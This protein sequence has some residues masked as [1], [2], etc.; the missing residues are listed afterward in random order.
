MQVL[1]FAFLRAFNHTAARTVGRYVFRAGCSLILWTLVSA[2]G[3]QTPTPGKKKTDVPP[4]VSKPAPETKAAPPETV[5]SDNGQKPVPTLTPVSAGA[6]EVTHVVKKGDTLWDLAKEYLKDPFR[7]PDVFQRNTDVVENPHWIYPGETIRIPGSEVKPDVL[8]RIATRPAPVS[9]RTVFAQDRM[10]VMP[11]RLGSSGEVLGRVSV[12]GVP[13]GEIEAAPF[14]DRIG[15]PR[16]SGTLSGAYDRPGI[17]SPAGE[18]RFQLKDRVFVQLPA[19]GSARAG[20]VL[21]SYRLGPQISDVGQLVIPTGILRI[22]SATPGQPALARIQKQFDEIRLDQPVMALNDLQPSVG[23]PVRVPQGPAEKVVYI[24]N[25]PVLPSLQSYVILTANSAN[26]VRVGD[27]FTLIDDTID[28][29]H[30]APAVPVA[31]A[32]VVR[33]TPFGVTAIIVDHEQPKIRTGMLARLS[34][35][36]P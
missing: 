22:E 29:R 16:G 4:P 33:V 30:P 21:L 27:Q 13:R 11:D 28:P 36:A 15:G 20:D 5:P 32:E 12:S 3:A 26:G 8:A 6:N 31:I 2:A 9:E 17:A 7:W 10:G 24:A 14:S 1:Q 23:S 19:T 34:A 35:R 25:D 18:R